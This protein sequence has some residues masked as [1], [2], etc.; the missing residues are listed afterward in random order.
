MF[1]ALRN[2]SSRPSPSVPSR[3][4]PFFYLFRFS[5]F[6]A[7]STSEQSI[8]FSCHLHMATRSLAASQLD[9]FLLAERFGAWP[10]LHQHFET[11]VAAWTTAQTALPLSELRLRI[12]PQLLLDHDVDLG[13]TLLLDPL[14]FDAMLTTRVS[15]IMMLIEQAFGVDN[16]HDTQSMFANREP[17]LAV[18]AVPMTAP[19]QAAMSGSSRLLGAS[20]VHVWVQG[21]VTAIS[22]EASY[23]HA[24]SFGCACLRTA[25][26]FWHLPPMASAGALCGQCT[27]I[28]QELPNETEVA[29]FWVAQVLDDS[30]Q[31]NVRVI[32]RTPSKQLCLCLCGRHESILDKILL[33]CMEKLF[34]THPAPFFCL[35][36]FRL[37][38]LCACASFNLFPCI[39]LGISSTSSALCYAPASP[40]FHLPLCVCLS[41]PFHCPPPRPLLHRPSLLPHTSTSPRPPGIC[42]YLSLYIL[43]VA[44]FL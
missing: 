38:P 11:H 16:G 10:Q 34:P 40:F 15:A 1:S 3:P 22:A 28:F 21:F 19:F 23:L 7:S 43:S 6:G 13:H 33:L 42:F 24:Q 35:V 27:E 4:N 2:P 20:A 31:E 18:R 36:F 39:L 12:D 8:V 26:N 14:A 9:D 37:F 17:L 32:I 5:P 29:P 25:V 30:T 41:Q 44:F